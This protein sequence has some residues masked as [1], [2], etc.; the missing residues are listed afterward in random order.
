MGGLSI[1]DWLFLSDTHCVDDHGLTKYISLFTEN[2]NNNK[3]DVC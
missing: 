3:K 2:E 1:S